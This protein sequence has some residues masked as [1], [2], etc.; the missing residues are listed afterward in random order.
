M[1][2]LAASLFACAA[3]LLAGT[4]NA[5]PIQWNLSGVT[6]NDNTTLSGSFFYDAA[7]STYSN[8]SLTSTAGTLAGYAY[9]TANSASYFLSSPTEFMVIAN[10]YS[11]YINLNFVAPLTA[12]GGTV[13]LELTDAPRLW[14]TGSW[15]CMNCGSPRVVTAGSVSTAS[16]NVPEPTSIALLGLALAGLGLSRRKRN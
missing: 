13:A 10:D 7:T 15:E 6:F 8:W 11:R 1:K 14:D 4:V 9:T 3:F 2:K 16:T 5:T 12:L